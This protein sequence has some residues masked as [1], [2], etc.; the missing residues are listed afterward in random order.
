MIS[1]RR[2]R[3]LKTK[4]IDTPNTR[5]YSR[6]ANFF[7]ILLRGSK[8][9][10]V[11]ISRYEELEEVYLDLFQKKTLWQSLHEWSA[12]VDQWAECPFEQI[13][14]EQVTQNILSLT[15]Y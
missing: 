9:E 3:A 4:P 7:V 11:G 12:L 6:Y 1:C 15:P 5:K 14:A 8:G 13:D 2:S 10:Q